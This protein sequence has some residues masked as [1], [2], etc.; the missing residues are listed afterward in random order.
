[1]ISSQDWKSFRLFTFYARLKTYFS[2]LIPYKVIRDLV[3]D[4]KT[5][6]WSEI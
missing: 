6:S 4:G 1:M 5:S 2:D 3:R